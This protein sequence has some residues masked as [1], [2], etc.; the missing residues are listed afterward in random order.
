MNDKAKGLF[1]RSCE[2]LPARQ[3]LADISW[4]I[5]LALIQRNEMER[6]AYL[7]MQRLFTWTAA[8]MLI[9]I[10]GANSPAADANS[11]KQMYLQYCSSCH[12]RDGKGD[13][14]VS[15]ELKVKVPDLTLLAKKNRGRFPL[16]DVMATID[17]RRFVRAHGDRDM[18]VWGETFYSETE[19]KKYRELT[20]LLKAKVIAEYVGT[21]Q[22]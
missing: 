5:Y 9:L 10:S 13:G 6:T 1:S 16:D 21:L 20:T 15:R 12:G 19:G 17:G 8:L 7:M 4:G 2:L 14:T 18:P 22:R 3:A 11:G